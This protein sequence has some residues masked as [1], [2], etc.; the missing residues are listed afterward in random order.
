MLDEAQCLLP[1]GR[2]RRQQQVWA[3]R[4]VP[5]DIGEEAQQGGTFESAAR[6]A[7]VVVG[8]GQEIPALAGSAGLS[9]QGARLINSAAVH[10]STTACY[11]SEVEW[12]VEHWEY[13]YSRQL[14]GEVFAPKAAMGEALKGAIHG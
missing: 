13:K 6:N 14:D 1:G 8:V 4:S 12:K 2:R 5:S 9:G 7:A 11:G 3:Q 10:A